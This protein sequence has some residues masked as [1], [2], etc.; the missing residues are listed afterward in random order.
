MTKPLVLGESTKPLDKSVIKEPPK[1][2][3]ATFMEY[4]ADGNAE[5]IHRMA[6]SAATLYTVPTNHTLF[7][8]SCF[9]SGLEVGN[10]NTHGEIQLL[11]KFASLD[12]IMLLS[13]HVDHIAG[14]HGGSSEL[15]LS[16]PMPVRVEQ[17]SKIVSS[18]AGFTTP[19]ARFAFLGFL[20]PK[21]I[22]IR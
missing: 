17:G 2:F 7:I 11:I 12:N 9:V 4:V 14:Q 16:F 5:Q 6:N 19:Q 3:S 10:V 22:S 13:T 1:P 18:L 20:L 15:S 21:K 8:T